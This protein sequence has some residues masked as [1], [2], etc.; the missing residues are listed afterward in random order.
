MPVLALMR[1]QSFLRMPRTCS[2]S[3]AARS[4]WAA[5]RSILLITPRISQPLSDGQVGVG[6]GL[7]LDALGGI[8]DQER[9]LA[10]G[11]GPGDLVVEVHVAG[12]VDEV[13]HVRLAV[14]LCSSS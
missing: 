12:R 11:Q 4:G 3:S 8:D 13:E 5:G 1:K 9:P 6:H 10:G 7:G 2:I 14:V